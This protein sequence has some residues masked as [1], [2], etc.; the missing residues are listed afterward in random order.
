[1]A[2]P[3][4][5]DKV[6]PWLWV[7]A[8]SLGAMAASKYTYLMMVIPIGFIAVWQ[9]KIPWKWLVF[10]LLAAVGVFWILNPTLWRDPFSRLA[11]ALLFHSRYTQGFDV[12]RAAY[13]WYQ[14]VI[15]LATALPWHPEV[16]FFF[17]LDEFIFWTGVVGSFTYTRKQP[18]LGVWFFSQFI[19]LLAWPTKWPQYSLIVV[20]AMCLLGSGL[21][22]WVYGWIKVKDDYWDY[23]EAML[24]RPPK[25]FWYLLI[26]FSLIL[27]VGKVWHEYDRAMDRR[28]WM[29]LMPDISPLPSSTIYAISQKST[30]EMIL[31]TDQGA[32]LWHSSRGSP[33]GDDNQVFNTRNSEILDNS[34]KT[35]F[36]DRDGNLWFGTDS[37]VSRY[38][39]QSWTNFTAT[40]MGL[41]TALVRAITQDSNG[42]I[43]VGTVAGL[44]SWDG[45]GWKIYLPENSGL[46]DTSVFTIAVQPGEKGEAIWFGTV[47]GVAR[48]EPEGGIWSN[49]EFSKNAAGSGGVSTLL[50][51]SESA[52]WA[53]T[54]GGGLGR[55]DGEEWYFYRNSNSQIP[56][57]LAQ[58]IVEVAPGEYWIGLGYSTEPGGLVAVYDGD[59]WT[60]YAENNSG[61]TGGEPISMA[62]DPLGRVWIG[63]ASSGL[64]IYDLS[65]NVTSQP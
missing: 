48:F 57:S 45:S 12:Q 17:T 28:G 46:L 8:V 34:V 63:T 43:W 47:T 58:T 29:I 23:F 2:D 14:S 65:F 27:S 32:A 10:Y 53:A 25:A 40:D 41:D 61:F 16:F 5:P 1:M 3:M 51:D 31:A 26:G 9:R 22:R 20:P 55:W 18:W 15:W 64:Q 30:G 21:L 56:T 6:N 42:V 39:G 24:P 49:W 36:E 13:P 59:T 38:D 7:S 52:L 35:V 37:G 50:V 54:L 62:V 19:I 33:W 60:R 11:D 44:V 4:E